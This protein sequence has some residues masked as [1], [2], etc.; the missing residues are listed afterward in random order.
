MAEFGNKFGEMLL[1]NA[2]EIQPIIH[3]RRLDAEH[4]RNVCNSQPARFHLF[5]EPAPDVLCIFR[6]CLMLYLSVVFGNALTRV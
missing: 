5:A 4:L 2:A 1:S 3:R 6:H